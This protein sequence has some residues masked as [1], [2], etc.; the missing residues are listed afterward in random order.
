ML[1]RVLIVMLAVLNMGVALWWWLLPQA[2]TAPPT[3]AADVAV[4]ELLPSSAPSPADGADTSFT[5]PDASITATISPK[6][7]EEEEPQAQVQPDVDE[8]ALALTSDTADGLVIANNTETE[9]LTHNEPEIAQTTPDAAEDTVETD[10]N[11]GDIAAVIPLDETPPE[12][13]PDTPEPAMQPC[14][15]LGPFT[16]M[17]KV[18]AALRALGSDVE[19]FRLREVIVPADTRYR[20]FIPPA[21]TREQAQAEVERIAAAG[22]SDYFI[23]NEGEDTHAIALGQFRNRQGAQNRLAQ[24]RAAGFAAQLLTTTEVPH[25]NWWIDTAPAARITP[26]MLQQRSNAAQW[27]ILDCAR[28]R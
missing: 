8:E 16:E 28:L 14:V 9:D 11:I 26:A 7:E 22:F 12:A 18:Q 23:I 25:S 5:R 17:A 20:I 2:A 10:G 6:D 19:R 21:P 15:S 27:Q 4:L 1:T 3:L 24:L 13:A